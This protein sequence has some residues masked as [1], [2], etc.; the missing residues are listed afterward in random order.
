MYTA[1]MAEKLVGLMLRLPEDLHAQLKAW[2][3]EEDRSLNNLIIRLLRRALAEW[4]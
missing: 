3:G 1:V 2:A 4:R